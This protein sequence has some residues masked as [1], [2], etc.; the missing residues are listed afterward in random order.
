[1][2]KLFTLMLT[3]LLVLTAV[4]CSSKSA[5]TDSDTPYTLVESGKL[6]VAMSPD[7]APMEFVDTTKSGQD[8]YV[9]FD[10]TLAKY[11]AS[12]LGLELVIKPMS[13]DA[14]MTAVQTGSVDMAI[15]GF[16]YM[17]D[18]AE[19]FSLS[20]YYYA[21]DNETAQT[22]IVSAD[23]AGTFSSV[24]DFQGMTIAAQGSSLQES[25]VT[26]QLAGI[27]ELSVY[28]AVDD[29]VLALKTGKV[30]GVAV[31]EGNGKAIIA[32]NPDLAMSGFLFEVDEEAEN[33]LILIN[34]ENTA[35][36]DV[37]NG[38]LAQ[39]L[40]AGLYGQWYE[41][42]LALALGDAYS[43]ISYDDD[44]NAITDDEGSAE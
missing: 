14:S 12:E 11:I 44:G 24:E 32:N 16:S 3:A 4:G 26:E 1:M 39:A 35:L 41:E 18:R 30:D 36:T 31:A 21:G 20:D 29:A 33:N 7:F 43:E 17:P 23:K 5:N 2:K 22:I 37:V 40:D 28:K 42:A 34:K 9:G 10:V 13:F 19:K 6:L 15:S 38:I 27:A 8:Q 25:L